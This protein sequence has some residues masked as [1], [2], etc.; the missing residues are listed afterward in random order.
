MAKVW[1][2]VFRSRKDAKAEWYDSIAGTSSRGH[3]AQFCKVGKDWFIVEGASTHWTESG[4][5][6]LAPIVAIVE[7]WL[8]AGGVVYRRPT[9]AMLKAMG[10]VAKAEGKAARLAAGPNP[11][12]YPQVPHGF[13]YQIQIDKWLEG[14]REC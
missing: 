3:E 2:E 1:R 5:H 6:D 9:E 7:R 14:W 4:R 10:E 13:L 11:P 12:E 8:A